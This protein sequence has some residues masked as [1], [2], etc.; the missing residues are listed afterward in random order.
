MRFVILDPVAKH[1]G[2]CSALRWNSALKPSTSFCFHVGRSI[3]AAPRHIVVFVFDK[4][5]TCQTPDKTSRPRV[6]GRQDPFRLRLAARPLSCQC[7]RRSRRLVDYRPRCSTLQSPNPPHCPP[8]KSPETQPKYHPV[9]RAPCLAPRAVGAR[10][11]SGEG[12]NR[13]RSTRT[14]TGTLAARLVVHRCTLGSKCRAHRT[15]HANA[16]KSA[17]QCEL[18]FPPTQPTVGFGV[19]GRA[20]PS[21]EGRGAFPSP[22]TSVCPVVPV[23]A[24]RH[25]DIGPSTHCMDA[26][27]FSA[28]IRF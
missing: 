21:G 13:P 20:A 12:G 7:Q 14:V 2:K 4:H 16:R 26:W 15:L 18:A 5:H 23:L 8:H 17:T 22:C 9:E 11:S 24:P 10:R 19:A 6:E 25:V 1:S 3:S 27:S 28:Q